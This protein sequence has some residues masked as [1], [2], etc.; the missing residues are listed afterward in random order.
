VVPRDIL[1]NW[2]RLLAVVNGRLQHKMVVMASGGDAP[3]KD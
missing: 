3:Q 2:R 1:Q